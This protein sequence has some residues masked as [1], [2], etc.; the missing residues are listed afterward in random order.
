MD[1]SAVVIA[2][3]LCAVGATGAIFSPGD[4][5]RSLDK[6]SWTPPNWL[7]PVA[8]TTL[9]IFIGYAGWL[10]WNTQGV[11]LAMGLWAAQLVFN[12]AW[13]W[14]FFGLKRMDLALVDVSALWV[15][16]AAFILAAWPVS[17]LAALLFV[18]YLIWVTIAGALNYR[19]ITMNRSVIRS[20]I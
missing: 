7:F 20:F 10:I 14:L 16:I 6:P 9:Y 18:P 12:G 3:L 4:W 19:M 5:Y 11:G 8:W 1:M 17:Q 13:S 2:G 15:A